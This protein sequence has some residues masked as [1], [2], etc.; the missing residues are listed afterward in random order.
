MSTRALTLGGAIVL[1]IA[2]GLAAWWGARTVDAHPRVSTTLTWHADIAPLFARQCASCHAGGSAAGGSGAAA[3]GAGPATSG[4]A[5]ASG[6]GATPTS[7]SRL[8]TLPLAT[9]ADVRPWIGAIREEVLERRMPPRRG[10]PGVDAG[11]DDHPLSPMERDLIV[12]WID[13]GSPEGK[14]GA[15]RTAT[16]WCRMHPEVRAERAGPC[17]ICGMALAPFLPD[18]TKRY[19]WTIEPSPQARG[20]A[21]TL[22]LSVTA[23]DD[24][25]SAPALVREFERVHEY[26]MHLFAVSEDFERFLHVHPE[27]GADG[28]FTVAW[29]PR[30]RDGGR[31]RT[32][33]R[34]TG[35]DEGRF[36]FYGDVLPVGGPPQL[37]QRVISMAPVAASNSRAASPAAAAPALVANV[38]GLTATLTASPVVATTASAATRTV[39]DG[40]VDGSQASPRAGDVQHVAIELTQTAGGKPVTDLEPYLGA[41]GHLFLVH[42]GHEEALHVHP[43][44][45]G[46]SAGGPTIG[47]DVLFPRAGT[48]YLWMQVQRHHTIVTL[49]FRVRVVPRA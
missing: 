12:G 6:G 5:V 26:P 48:Y 33:L 40:R 43:E 1:A 7:G 9:Y 49:P 14:P 21:R 46:T 13:G 17:P 44:T 36:W 3:T 8:S 47:F 10:T 31:A 20:R 23:R 2:L 38:A 32:G 41:W 34:H 35:R 37:L 29:P 27:L 18:L 39:A 28:R 45:T 4:G 24:S 19:G 11:V 15:E 42:E 16:F 22:T 25:A 30:E